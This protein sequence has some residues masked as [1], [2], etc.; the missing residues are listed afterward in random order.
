MASVTTDE[1]II[2]ERDYS[3][4]FSIKE[5]AMQTLGQKYFEDIDLA[6]LNVGALGFTLEQIANITEDAFNSAS[7][8]MNEA[9]P[10]KASIPESIYTHA[11]IFQID[12][13]FIQCASCS[14]VMLLQQ[15]EILKY[16][17]TENGKTTFF[18]DKKTVI[19]VEGIPFTLD[20]D[21]KIEAQE[22][23]ISGSETE[24]NFSAQYVMD[25][26]NSISDI[27]DPYLKARRTNNGYLIIQFT[28]HQVE[29]TE[30]TDNI[31]SNTKINY[32]V[33]EFDFDGQLAGFDIFYKAPTDKEY[34]Q[35]TKKIMF[36][37]PTKQP[38]CYY[39]LKNENT[40]AISFSSRDGYF[41]PDFNSEIK[42]VLYTSLGKKGCFDVYNGSGYEFQLFS[43]V[44]DY[45][46]SMTIAVK[47][48]SKSDGG[49][50]GLSLEGLQALTVE[51]YS[52][53]QEISTD[54]DIMNY[55][56]NYKYRHGNEM[57][58]I[59]RRDDITERLFSAFLLMKNGDYIYP[60]NT[61][62]LNIQPDDFDTNY[63]NNRFTLNPGHIFTYD[64]NS[65]DTLQIIP[66]VMCYETEKVAELFNQYDFLY[67][68]PFLI[69]MT[70]KPNAIGLYQNV[71]N[72]TAVL[73]Y[74]NSNSDSFTQ[75]I[76]SKI[77]LNRGL[78]ASKEYD[79]SLSIVPSSSM[80]PYVE[81][82]NTYEGN[83][84]RIFAGFV[85][86]NGIEA[87]YIE[88]YPTAIEGVDN[89]SVKYSAKI[90]TDDFITSN[91]LFGI[92]NAVRPDGKDDPIYI[93]IAD[94]E[95]NIYIY[96]DDAITETNRFID[97]FDDM[98][99][100]VLTNTYSTRS[101]GLTF[102]KP[103][104]MM[105]STVVFSNIGTKEEPKLSANLSLL[106]VIKADLINNESNFN[107]FITMLTSNYEYMESCLPILRNNTHIDLKFYNTYGKSV[108][109][110]IGDEEELIDTINIT[111]KF[112]VTLQDGVDE[113]DLKEKL[114][115]FIKEFIEK[116]NSSGNNN[117]YISNLIRAIE[118]KFA[119]VHHLKFL[120]INDYETHYQTIS[121]K[122]TDLENL[123]KEERRKYV[124]EM[125]V[126]DKAN[127]SLII[128]TT[129]N[130]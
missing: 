37:L 36:S 66:D 3:D 48:V 95:I 61:M 67:T 49:T 63:E 89:T 82:F 65:M 79:L 114:K 86:N 118:N 12:S 127:V 64:E 13:T 53:A 83:N 109:Y 42:I 50:D 6:G 122:E 68:N 77:Q 71:V 107:E 9:F 52:N 103:M 33:L 28:A 41:Q 15:E 25:F 23:Q 115:I 111:I 26:K 54:N 102:V 70:K 46:Q 2:V 78:N 14:F 100:F 124:P 47:V 22:K 121:V 130:N 108:N 8:L 16:G 85:D 32:P 58:V 126:V 72:E 75:F 1:N 73:D 31:I 24:Y 35:L 45:N 59:K 60:T 76:T 125:L 29:R 21:I 43:D 112:K 20:Y 11:A 56:Y 81:N 113:V 69:S 30:L 96:Y 128:T 88:M 57:L 119:E 4:N 90:Q 10:N 105:R 44:Y 101:D 62:N 5:T 117:L 120:G 97:L 18:I 104:N 38:F 123:T 106:P 129:K 84:V 74:V 93:P 99:Y 51:S 7:I 92:L 55:F 39:R 110:F 94:T 80:D 40:L 116:L 98:R 19:E 27:N 91:G 34:T 17:K 87:G